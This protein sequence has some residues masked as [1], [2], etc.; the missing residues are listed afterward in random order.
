MCLFSNE[1]LKQKVK[2]AE[3]IFNLVNEPEEIPAP[4]AQKKTSLPADEPATPSPAKAETPTNGTSYTLASLSELPATEILKLTKNPST[5]NSLP[6]PKA[7]SLVIQSTDAFVDSLQSQGLNQQKQAVGEKLFKFVKA[8]G[9]GRLAGKI[10]IQLLD[11]E[12]LRSL[13]HLMNSYPSVLKEKSNVI[14]K[15]LS[16]K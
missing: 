5:T 6:V 16:A 12:E 3:E 1:I 8:A 4:I 15:Q 9:G 11:N 10:T 13:A 7:D 14:S 2:E